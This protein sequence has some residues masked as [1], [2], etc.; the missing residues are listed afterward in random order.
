[1]FDLFILCFYVLRR[2]RKIL[3]VRVF[4]CEDGRRVSLSKRKRMKEIIRIGDTCV[5]LCFYLLEAYAD[6]GIFFLG[7]PATASSVFYICS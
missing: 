5:L 4:V 7:E 6:D 1:M 2:G 3:L